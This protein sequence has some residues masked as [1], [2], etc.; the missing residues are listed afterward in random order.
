MSVKPEVVQVRMWVLVVCICLFSTISLDSAWGVETYMVPMRDGVKLATDVH[1][2]EGDGPWPVILVRTPYDRDLERVGIH[3]EVEDVSQLRCARLVDLG[4]T[5]VRAGHGREP[6]VLHIEDL[7]EQ[8]PGRLKLVRLEVWISAFRT[9]P[10][11]VSH[12]NALPIGAT[13]SKFP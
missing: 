3:P 7:G 5:A 4:V 1:L 12:G 6:L 2:P 8:S 13:K 9:L 10:I 11:L